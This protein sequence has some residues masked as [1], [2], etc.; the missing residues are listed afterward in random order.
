MSRDLFEKR[1]L[2]LN[3]I[4]EKVSQQ[5]MNITDLGASEVIIGGIADSVLILN[6]RYKNL[7]HDEIDEIVEI[8]KEKL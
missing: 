8:L 7:N 1:F 3:T 2:V 5:I 4:A 6:G